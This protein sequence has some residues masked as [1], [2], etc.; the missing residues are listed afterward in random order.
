MKHSILSILF[1]G[2]VM[3][4]AL[5]CNDKSVVVGGYEEA[6][7]AD[8]RMKQAART[9]VIQKSNK[10]H[11]LKFVKVLSAQSQVVAGMNY[12]LRIEV[13]SANKT[14]YAEA[15]VY[16]KPKG[17]MRL[18]QWHWLSAQTGK[19]CS[20]APHPATMIKDEPS[21]PIDTIMCAQDAKECPDGTLVGRSGSKCEFVCP[22][23]QRK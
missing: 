15:V 11:P 22:H 10:S 9:A 18:I 21:S 7:T 6:D 3:Q 23:L 4:S 5:A 16:Q 13:K 20:D 19:G 1:L 14:R 8:T 2:C 12:N 17:E